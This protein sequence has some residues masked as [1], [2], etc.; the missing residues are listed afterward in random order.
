MF[1]RLFKKSEKKPPQDEYTEA[2]FKLIRDLMDEELGELELT[3]D[4]KLDDLGFNSIKYIHLLLSLEDVVKM[5]LE[6]I[7]SETDLS[8]LRTIKD[9]TGML[10]RL[11]NNAA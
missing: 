3:E 6:K 7:V 1:N 5:D 10:T 2:V 11:S 9:I 8:D 4:T